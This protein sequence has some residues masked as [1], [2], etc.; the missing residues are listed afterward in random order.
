[1]AAG[2]A[3]TH[4][5]VRMRVRDGLRAGEGASREFMGVLHPFYAQMQSGPPMEKGQT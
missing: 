4:L 3:V 5:R 2:R 1:M